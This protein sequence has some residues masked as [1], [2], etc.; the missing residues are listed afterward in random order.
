MHRSP[1]AVVVFA[2][3]LPGLGVSQALGTPTPGPLIAEFG[4]VFDVPGMSFTTPDIDYR[5]V[6]DVRDPAE[7]TNVRNRNIE[8]VARY[9]N[10]HGRA[11]IPADRIHAVLVLH[12]AAA[13]GALTD[14][15]YQVRYGVPNPDREMLAA[16]V[17][18]GARVIV[19]GQS[20]MSRG[21]PAEDLAPGVELALSAMTAL[22]AFQHDGYALIAFY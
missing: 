7:A 22:I 20:A 10:M 4:P 15:A 6:F 17:Q 16:L 12:G 14:E 5:A 21:F 18:A 19:C 13:R 1:L 11:G 8:T 2:L 9:I 3:T